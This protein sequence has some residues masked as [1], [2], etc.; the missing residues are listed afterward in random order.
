MAGVA[1]LGYGTVGSGVVDVIETHREMLSAKAGK[2]VYIKYIVDVREFPDS[3][4]SDKF[5][6]DFSTLENDPEIETVV[7]AIGG[8]RIAYEFTKRALAAGKNV[9]TSNKE[10][11]AHHAVELFELARKNNVRYMY[12]ASVGGGIPIIRPLSQCLAANEITEIYGILN[13]TTNYILTRMITASLSFEEA[14]REAQALGYAEADPGADIH[15]DDACR[16][17]CIL[18]SLAFGSHI[19]PDQV[20]I[21]GIDSIAPEDI[22]FADAEGCR[23]KLL[24]RAKKLENGKLYVSVAPFVIPDDSP[25]ASIDGVFNGILV[26]GDSV[27]D[28][29]FYGRGAGKYPTASA[30]VADVVDT[31]RSFGDERRIE[32]GKADPDLVADCRKVSHRYMVRVYGNLKGA[33]D[34][35]EKLFGEVEAIRCSAV[36]IFDGAFITPELPEEKLLAGIENMKAAGVDVRNRLMLL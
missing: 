25:L 33:F 4:Y 3:P 29:M 9:V 14:L 28:V 27:D 10:L 26:H 21:E 8:R 2:P 34:A 16:K 19:H 35:A 1:V 18:A 11:V 6:S 22:A 36:S 5:V 30:V 13:G 31:M 23:I 7:E 20:R 12:E 15:G 32:W 17:I 24:G